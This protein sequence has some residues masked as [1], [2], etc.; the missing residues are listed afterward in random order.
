MP[1]DGSNVRWKGVY[2]AAA[3]LN[4]SRSVVEEVGFAAF[5]VFFQAFVLAGQYFLGGRLVFTGG[6]KETSLQELLLLSV[7]QQ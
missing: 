6:K 4:R 5:E 3:G 1:R 2:D 7:V